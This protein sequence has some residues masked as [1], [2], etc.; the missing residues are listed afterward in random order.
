MP[1]AVD[2]GQLSVDR[3]RI[4]E[5]E[6]SYRLRTAQPPDG[7]G[8]RSAGIVRLDPG[9]IDEVEKDVGKSIRRYAKPEPAKGGL[10]A[11]PAHA[12]IDMSLDE[13]VQRDIA[14]KL[15]LVLLKKS[16]GIWTPATG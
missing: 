16:D 14:R 7:F 8:R 6:A 2:E 12:Q 3:Q 13:K 9:A 10:P 15:I 11:N 1:S 4:L 5:E